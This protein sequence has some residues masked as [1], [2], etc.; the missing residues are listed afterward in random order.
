MFKIHNLIL[1]LLAASMMTVPAMAQ[2]PDIT[3]TY[4]N[5]TGR[6]KVRLVDCGSGVCG[7]VIWMSNPVND[8]NNP[9]AS[10]RDRP[11]VGL[12]AVT[13][14]PTGSGTYAGS[15]YNTENGKTYSGKAKLS[16]NGIE[17]SGCVLGGLLCK[18]SVWRRVD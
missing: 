3:G 16:D 13:L 14:K 7:T 12:Q 4:V 15:L 11:V 18:N 5:D 10:K 1:P 9:D 6:T 2:A 17:L 8:V